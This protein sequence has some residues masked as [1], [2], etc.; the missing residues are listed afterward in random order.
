MP[1][2]MLL[3]VFS[4]YLDFQSCTTFARSYTF[5][6]LIGC[7]MGG[8]VLYELHSCLRY[9]HSAITLMDIVFVRHSPRLDPKQELRFGM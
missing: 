8:F 3:S 6:S 1:S 7:G 9:S 2:L 4:D 5:A